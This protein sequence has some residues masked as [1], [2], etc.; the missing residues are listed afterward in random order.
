[1]TEDNQALIRKF[2]AG[3]CTANEQDRIKR[4]MQQ[5]D[6]RELL[7]QVLNDDWQQFKN[8]NPASDSYI[9]NFQQ[10]LNKRL[11]EVNKP[12]TPIVKRFNF[13][14]YAAVL[15][16][17]ILTLAYGFWQLNKKGHS[18]VG[19]NQLST[20][21]PN[22]QR[23]IIV[24]P[25]SSV[26]TLG[27]GS[28]LHYP[29]QFTDSI[30][31]ISLQGE[32]F[33]QVTKNKYKPFIIHTGEIQTK[34]LGT[35]FK[36]TAFKGQNIT[37]A[38]ATGKVKVD[39]KDAATGKMHSLAVLQPGNEVEWNPVSG[40][41]LINHG[42]IDEIAGWKEGRL[43]FA[44][45]PLIKM[46]QVLERWYNVKIDLQNKAISEYKMNIAVDGNKPVTHTLEIL[47]ATI[48][49]SYSIKGKTIIIK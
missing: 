18:P 45:M 4:L 42:D 11:P 16:F 8:E 31:E 32:A 24:L 49:A 33:F 6:F 26:V 41:T 28:T 25:D 14:Q 23:S 43:H 13:L 7:D 40:K 30:R 34:V 36:I 17:F 15:A 35:S 27:A 5:R 47:K 38:V 19:T 9:Q 39:R 22:G 10:Q 1:M 46:V 44:G 3:N 20:H 12:N 37:V 29:E 48:K 2:I 21:N